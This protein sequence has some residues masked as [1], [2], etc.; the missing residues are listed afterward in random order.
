M[1]KLIFA[2]FA[3][4][5]LACAE[6][7]PKDYVTFSGK[8]TNKNSD[9]IKIY[10]RTYSKVIKVNE[11]GTFSDTLNVIKGKYNFYDGNEGTSVF[12]EN[13]YDL[14]MTLDTDMF[15]ETIKFTGVGAKNNNFL[16]EEALLK[17]KLLDGDFDSFDEA[18]LKLAI[19]NV[20]SE[21][22]AFIDNAVEIDTMITNDSRERLDA[23]IQSY[24][25]YYGGIIALRKD[26]PKG[27]PSPV[28]KDYEN[29]KG[30]TT[31]LSDL[32]GKYVYV[33]V[34]ATWCGPCK[35]EIPHLK[36]LEAEFH[37]KNITFVSMSIDDDKRHNDSWEKAH[38]AWKEMVANKELTGI[39]IMAPKGW[40]SD[41]VK[42]Y[43]IN[44]IPRFI[45]IDPNG[46]V[47]DPNAP[48]PS[49]PK[50]KEL[51]QTLI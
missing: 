7:K 22:T 12:L 3:L 34:W 48:R 17:E 16:A 13:G 49:D 1:K 40:E 35:V 41:F 43:K 4:A 31:S 5:V 6:E 21:V 42:N 38:E 47:F 33:D 8:I 26:F 44:G 51:L 30:G 19:E 15:D 23:T 36:K 27:S 25:R 11:D 2:L 24:E 10:N 18:Q 9:E 50:L 32:K 45:L 37:N 28:F 29:Y 20:K 14:N 46:N 39:Q